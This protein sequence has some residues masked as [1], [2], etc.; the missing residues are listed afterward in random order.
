MKKIQTAIDRN[1][2]PLFLKGVNDYKVIGRSDMNEPNDYLACWEQEI[3]PYSKTN[4]EILAKTIPSALAI[5]LN[6]KSDIDCNI[7]TVVN[8]IFWYYYFKNKQTISFEISLNEISRQLKETL[9]SNKQNLRT[10]KRWG[11]AEWNSESGLWEPIIRV[12]V[13]IK[14]QYQGIDFMPENGK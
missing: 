3:I 8:H 10:D 14:D 13:A 5:L 1:E 9:L 12:A 7:Y 4:S 6:D 11:G 2:L